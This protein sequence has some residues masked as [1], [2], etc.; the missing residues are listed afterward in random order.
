MSFNTSIAC[1]VPSE[2]YS[3]GFCFQQCLPGWT[4]IGDVCV[5]NCPEGFINRG[6]TCEPPSILRQPVKSFL[7]PC[8]TTEID[9]NGD[10]YEP[11]TT[12]YVSGPNN[13]IQP[14]TVGCGCIK[15]TLDQRIQ[16]PTG[17]SRYANG[18]VTSCPPD[19]TDIKDSEGR[20]ISLYCTQL[21]PFKENTKTRWKSIGGLCVKDYKTRIGTKTVATTSKTQSELGFRSPEL[22]F[23]LP[24]T[25]ASYLAAKPNGSSLQDRYRAGQS[26]QNNL[27]S[28]PD[29]NSWLNVLN[30]SWVDI[31]WSPA[32][33]VTIII[34]FTVVIFVGPYLFPLV[35]QGFGYLVRGLGLAAEG[36]AAGAGQLIRGTATGAGRVAESTGGVLAD[37]ETTVGKTVS[38]ALQ[39]PASIL[40]ARNAARPILS[41][42]EAL[43]QL[44]EA[45]DAL[46]VASR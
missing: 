18:C 13:T 14:K 9:L 6:D 24:S 11:Q 42:V 38:T 28:S 32:K 16:C 43:K 21:C 20:I 2:E 22:T 12:T 3:N 7:S 40:A 36:T 45:Q 41:Q 5:Q 34:I 44:K 1:A 39:A 37:L 30:D 25:M 15:T 26:L 17:Y 19:Y 35:A 8:A 29:T 33:L 27:A 23:G 4:P 10:C 46:A 31:F